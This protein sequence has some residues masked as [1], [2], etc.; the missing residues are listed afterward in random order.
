MRNAN[1]LR[2][3]VDTHWPVRGIWTGVML[4]QVVYKI[5]LKG[6]MAVGSVNYLMGVWVILTFYI[7]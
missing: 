3:P 6:K 2:L 4:Y 5:M 7:W 1:I